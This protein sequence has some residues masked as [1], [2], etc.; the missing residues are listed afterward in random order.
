MDGLSIAASVF[1]V[2]QLTAACLKLGRKVLGHSK[3]SSDSLTEIL[4]TL[5]SF[6]RTIKNLHTHLE[7]NEQDHAR[8]QAL[9]HLNKPLEGCESALIMVQ[10][11]LKNVNFLGRYVVGRHFDKRLRKAL[12]TV[13]EARTLFELALDA[14]QR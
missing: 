14:D 3:H 5:D 10:N 1:A 2:V 11:R 12:R 4:S 7:T 9:S 8:L 13:E 6:N